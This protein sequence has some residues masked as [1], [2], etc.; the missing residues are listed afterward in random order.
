MSLFHKAA[1]LIC[2]L[3]GAGSL[4]AAGKPN[5]I[6]ILADDLAIGDLSLFNGGVCETP[7]LDALIGESVY[8]DRAY[9]GSP[10]CA[11]S[12][13]ALLTGRFPHRT[14]CV[15]LNQ[16]KYPNLTRIYKD[17]ITL[18][19]LF[20]ANGYATG[21]V[22]KWHSGNGKGYHPL[23]RG[24]DEFVGFNASVDIKSYFDYKLDVQGTYEE[25]SGEYLTDQLTRRAIDFLDKHKDHPFFLHLAHYAPHRPLSAPAD[26]IAKYTAKGLGEKTAKV[27]AMVEIL[28]KA[29]GDL[30]DELDRLEIRENT[31]ILFASD[32]GPD[33]LVDER[34]NLD[35]RGTKYTVY[36]GGIHVP[37]LV[38]WKGTLEPGRR[39][40]VVQFTDVFPTLT[41]ICELKPV[42]NAKPL[43]GASFAG[44]LSPKYA[45]VS[46]PEH[47]FWQWNR[48]V[49]LYSHNAA[50]REG[51]WK[52][53]RPFITK[54]IPTGES[55]EDPVLYHL[56]QDPDEGR[57]VGPYNPH[58]RDRLG[59]LLEE[60]TKD[61]EADRR[62]NR[63]A[64]TKIAP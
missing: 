30:I 27:Y 61:V 54:N 49:P 14:G 60:W 3:V 1:L 51:D 57:D 8:F 47:R 46:L 31:I 55:N 16:I 50:V 62:R 32:N 45:P 19:N 10:V 43:D 37:F 56:G 6:L 29:I 28:D 63:E 13:A 24:F 26:T 53:V 35:Q 58:I 15:S 12:R 41:E 25:F 17:E 59:A 21:L 52:L 38:N 5:V 44:L 18:G 39:D 40:E 33:P 2:A 48:T 23:D 9:S 36:E 11:P 34:F 7:R 64:P 4:G 20:K 22:G 42:P